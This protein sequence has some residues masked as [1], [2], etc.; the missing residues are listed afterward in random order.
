MTISNMMK[1]AE[2]FPNRLK[3]LWEKE[4]L[5]V[6]SNFSFS[7]SV[8]K[9]LVLQTLKNQGLFGK[10]LMSIYIVRNDSKR[11]PVQCFSLTYTQC[12]FMM[13]YYSGQ[14]SQTSFYNLT[15]NLGMDEWLQRKQS[16]LK[17]G[18]TKFS[19]ML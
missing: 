16:C 14:L 6:M 5:L 8:F 11:C 7:H 1:M 12:I 17:Q 9:R 19:T 4:K 18:V 13:Q 3:T 2:T 10:G 15:P